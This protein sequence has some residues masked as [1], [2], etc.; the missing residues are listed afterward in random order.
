MILY[1]LMGVI[2][3]NSAAVWPTTSMW[4]TIDTYCLRQR[5]SPKN[6]ESSY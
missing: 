2:F 4:L 3:P 1:G 6:E 5:C